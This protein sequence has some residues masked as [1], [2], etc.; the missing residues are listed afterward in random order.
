MAL[1]LKFEPGDLQ[2]PLLQAPMTAKLSVFDLDG[3]TFLQIDGF[4][5]ATKQLKGKRS[6]SVRLG[7]EA[8]M[9]LRIA[10]DGAFG[11]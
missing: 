1:V 7:R 8:A 6:Q 9:Q 3:E 4:G 2:R 5:S 10:I 11:T